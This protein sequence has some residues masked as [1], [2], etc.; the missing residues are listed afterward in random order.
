[1]DHRADIYSLGVVFY[2]MLTGELPLG[3]F[4]PP[5]QKAQIDVRLDDVVLRALEKEPGRRYQ[6]ASEVKT[7][8]ETIMTEQPASTAG[9][10]LAPSG[11]AARRTE[12]RRRIIVPAAVAMLFVLAVFSLGFGRRKTLSARSRHPLLRSCRPLTQA[13]PSQRN[14]K[15]LPAGITFPAKSEHLVG[16]LMITGLRSCR[17]S[18]RLAT[19]PTLQTR[20][21]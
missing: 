10:A 2:E 21:R 16:G 5:S 1:V 8:M 7:D 9:A 15:Q 19:L 18:P 14:R 13:R 4:L 3:K 20:K 6:H 17:R 11:S 12:F